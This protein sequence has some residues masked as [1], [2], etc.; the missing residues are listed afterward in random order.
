[1]VQVVDV[2]HL[3]RLALLGLH[4]SPEVINV[5]HNQSPLQETHIP[6]RLCQS[7]EVDFVLPWDPQ[8]FARIHN[9]PFL[10]LL[11][12]QFFLYSLLVFLTLL[13]IEVP[14]N[15]LHHKRVVRT[16]QSR[17]F[18]LYFL[19]LYLFFLL[20]LRLQFPILLFLVVFLL[21]EFTNVL[22]SILL[23][24]VGL[25]NNSF[26]KRVLLSTFFFLNSSFKQIGVLIEGRKRLLETRSQQILRLLFLGFLLAFFRL[27]HAHILRVNAVVQM[28][29]FILECYQQFLLKTSKFE[30]VPDLLEYV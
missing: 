3:L 20:F 25:F 1:M 14:L 13:R 29:L 10:A 19:F 9:L 24:L 15:E 6:L 21:K 5:S 7:T 17:C 26:H 18:L 8:D 22:I 2:D 23:T 16:L 11:L 30:F 27:G 12:A 4:L 28:F